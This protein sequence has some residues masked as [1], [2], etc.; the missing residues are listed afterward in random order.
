MKNNFKY[1]NTNKRYHTLS[2]YFKNKYNSKVAKI[3][4]DAG[5]SCPNRDGSKNS[6]GCLFCPSDQLAGFKQ[7]QDLKEQIKQQ[8]Q[9][10][11]KKWP[12]CKY[13]LFFQSYSN[14]YSDYFTNINNY[15]IYKKIDNV[16]SLAIA[17]RVD[18]LD[19]DTLDYLNNLSKTIDVYLEL[20][21]QTANDTNRQALNCEYTTQDFI[22]CLNRI[23]QTNCQVTV[24]IINGLP[25]ESKD[26]MI[27]TAKFLNELNIH[28]IKIHM[29]HID[30]TTP[31]AKIYLEKPFPILSEDEY[32]D[33]VI[34]QLRHLRAEI[35]ISRLTGDG[36]KDQL[37]APQWSLNKTQVLNTIDKKMQ[38]RN[39]YQGDLCETIIS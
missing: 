16:V 30:K 33:I 12:D 11:Q 24:H 31:L 13:Q 18:C 27:E 39:V 25:N 29:L 8:K 5:Y 6:T 17:T 22:D 2:Y 21:L 37:I 15:E 38:E 4:L 36:V 34:E 32:T 3:C 28:A 19:Q 1:S 9:I 14:T 10:I 35:V 20:G 23:K 26:Q 7:P